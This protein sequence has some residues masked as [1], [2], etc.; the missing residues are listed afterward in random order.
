M[1]V[2]FKVIWRDSFETEVEEPGEEREVATS[3]LS[4]RDPV[5]L[6]YS[7]DQSSVK[8]SVF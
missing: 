7:T 5:T 4:G 8:S 6:D 1:K 3:R 2:F